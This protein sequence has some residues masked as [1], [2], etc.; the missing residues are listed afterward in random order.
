MLKKERISPEFVGFTKK[1]FE[2]TLMFHPIFL[3]LLTELS[4]ERY[5][6]II[7][8]ISYSSFPVLFPHNKKSEF[9]KHTVFF[10]DW[11]MRMINNPGSLVD[12][13]CSYMLI[14]LFF[15]KLGYFQTESNPFLIDVTVYFLQF[16]N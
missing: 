9:G 15:K 16:Q 6:G 4:R 10:V 1:S 7:L 11:S 8:E 14:K 5:S 2:F 13:H 12:K 3:Y